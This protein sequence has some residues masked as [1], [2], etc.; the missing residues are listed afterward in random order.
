MMKFRNAY[1]RRMKWFFSIGILFSLLTITLVFISNSLVESRSRESIFTDTETIPANK[2]GLLLGTAKYTKN[3]WINRFYQYRIDAVVDLYK[4]GKISYIIVSGDNGTKDYN[5]PM[6]M[7]ED[8]IK[9]DIPEEKIFLDYAGFRTLDSVVRCREIFGQNSI[10]VIS[11]EF[12]NERAIFIAENKEMRA[13]G[14]NAESLETTSGIKTY[15][16]EYLARVK[17]MLDL[18][19]LDVQPKYLGDKILIP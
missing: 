6:M 14:Y 4:A 11:Q 13:I 19:V 3:G 15:T 7:K 18:Y 8:L 10:T 12:H 9:E 17:M 2:V 1:G 5:E 16:R